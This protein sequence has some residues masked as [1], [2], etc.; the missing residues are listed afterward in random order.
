MHLG[1]DIGGT[2]VETVV[3][4]TRKTGLAAAHCDTESQH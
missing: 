4:M 3:P 1:M 2:K